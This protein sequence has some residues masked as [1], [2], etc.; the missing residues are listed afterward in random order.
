MKL[1]RRKQLNLNVNVLSRQQLYDS[2]VP[3]SPR[4][5]RRA[6]TTSTMAESPLTNHP[7]STKDE[8]E[9]D[10]AHSDDED[11]VPTATRRPIARGRGRRRAVAVDDSETDTAFKTPLRS[12]MRRRRVLAEIDPGS[13]CN[14]TPRSI[15]TPIV[16]F[17]SPTKENQCS[18]CRGP[19][20]G[21]V[22]MSPTPEQ[23]V[24]GYG[25]GSMGLLSGDEDDEVF[26]PFAFVK[27]IPSR[28][29][30]STPCPRDIPP[31]T[32]SMPEAT[33]VLD[34]DE[35]LMFSSLSVIP[36]AEYSFQTPFQDQKYKVYMTLRPGVQE[37]LQSMSKVYELF[38]YTSA[39][40]S[41]AE[42]ILDVLDPKRNL[43]RHRLYQQDCVC[44]LGHYI[45]DLEVLERDLAKMVV[46][47]NSPH[48]YPYHMMNTIPVKSWSGDQTDRELHKLIPYL[49]KLSGAE[50]FREALKRRKDHFHRLLS[51]D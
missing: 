47:D 6:R 24:F 2:P 20:T 25:S 30:Q 35:T 26:N 13:P 46:L 39:K 8:V 34:L 18:P 15:Y 48:T 3:R 10:S 40:K 28:S 29:Q 7:V 27:N 16:R 51:E 11:F 19:R 9:P 17:L 31:K 1:R 37:F 44:V 12:A 41:Y 49:E 14:I 45:K 4:T 23:C 5:P 38:V 22:L 42:K 33:M 21:D 43:F 50:D 36:D 32:R